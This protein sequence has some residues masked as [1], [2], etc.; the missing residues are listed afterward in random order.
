[1]AEHMINK[2]YKHSV[3]ITETGCW[4]WL[5]ADSG[6]KTGEYGIL[7]IGNKNEKAHRLSYKLFVGEIPQGL[8]VLHRCD[9][10]SC[11]NPDHLFL[12]TISDNMKDR[13]KKGRGVYPDQKG[14]NHSQ[15]KLTEDDVLNIRNMHDNGL[16]MTKIHAKYNYVSLATISNVCHKKSWRHI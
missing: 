13:H 9:T 16:S 7:R 12:G 14:S 4:I 1:M 8:Q 11:I 10:P 3:P 15:S 5:G 2:L 6:I